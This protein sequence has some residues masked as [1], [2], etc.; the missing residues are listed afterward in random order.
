M[1]LD[2]GKLAAEMMKGRKPKGE[3][4]DDEGMSDLSEEAHAAYDDYEEAKKG[5]DKKAAARALKAFMQLC[6]D[7]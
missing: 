5:G 4:P 7:D 6:D 2:A 1:A 3:E